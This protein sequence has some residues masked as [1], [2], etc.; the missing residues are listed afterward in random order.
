MEKFCHGQRKVLVGEEWF[1]TILPSHLSRNLWVSD[2]ILINGTLYISGG[3]KFAYCDFQSLIASC[4]QPDASRPLI[5]SKIILFS[6]QSVLSFGQQVVSVT[7]ER[8][9]A[10][11]PLIN[12]WSSISLGRV[13]MESILRAQGQVVSSAVLPNGDVITVCRISQPIGLQYKF[14][15]MSLKCKYFNYHQL[16]LILSFNFSVPI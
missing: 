9:V 3:G 8:V 13:P 15:K 1:K 5:W 11:H 10:H 2:C 4:R 6:G 12:E 7:R 16:H 14:M